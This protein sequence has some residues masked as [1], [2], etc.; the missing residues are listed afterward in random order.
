[1]AASSRVA[2]VH[3]LI[4][5]NESNEDSK[6][7]D[8]VGVGYTK[9]FRVGEVTCISNSNNEFNLILYN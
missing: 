3:Q 4:P 2:E 8:A 7:A 1:M 9:D 6:D 5:L